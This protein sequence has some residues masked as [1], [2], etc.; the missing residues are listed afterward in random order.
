MTRAEN[1]HGDA[2]AFGLF[3][4]REKLENTNF[5]ALQPYLVL[6]E[7]ESENQALLM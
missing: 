2:L 5:H 7:T 1:E 6:D 4:T 3:R